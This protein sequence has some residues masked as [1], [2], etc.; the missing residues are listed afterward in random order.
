M[1]LNN[2]KSYYGST[3]IGPFNYKFSA[4]IGP[5]GSGKSNIIDAMMFI[6]GKRATWMRLKKLKELIHS[7]SEY[8][9]C[10]EAYV[11]VV[12]KRVIEFEDGSYEI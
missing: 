12:F 9:D 2:F 6:F 3:E 1:V 10:N 11:E 8:P 5:N 7:S 4:I